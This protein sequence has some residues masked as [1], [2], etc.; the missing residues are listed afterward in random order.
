MPEH[1]AVGGRRDPALL[2]G[3]PRMQPGLS[4]ASRG[5]DSSPSSAAAALGQEG[6]EA[7][8]PGCLSQSWKQAPG[9]PALLCCDHK[10]VFLRAPSLQG[11]CAGV[12]QRRAV[13]AGC[14][15]VSGLFGLVNSLISWGALGG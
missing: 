4:K 1:E 13:A 9:V 5:S 12:A 7:T 2:Q 3:F 15:G 8:W 10:A 6:S 14:L 11:V